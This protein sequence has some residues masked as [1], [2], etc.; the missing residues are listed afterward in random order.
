VEKT[1]TLILLA[2]SVAHTRIRIR[3]TYRDLKTAAH[4]LRFLS[5]LGKR[6]IDPETPNIE[7]RMVQAGR[8]CRRTAPVEGMDASTGAA[9]GDGSE[10]GYCS[11]AL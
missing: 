10:S 4:K 2:R 7:Q 1:Q 3:R 9:C 8:R 11:A 6:S 5:S